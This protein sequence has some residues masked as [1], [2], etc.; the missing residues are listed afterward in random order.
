MG[1]RLVLFFSLLALIFCGVSIQSKKNKSVQKHQDLSISDIEKTAN[2]SPVSDSLLT[3]MT[4][5]KNES[6]ELR[7]QGETQLAVDKLTEAIDLRWREPATNEEYEKLAWI[8]TNRAYLYHERQGDFLAAKEDYLSALRQFESCEPSSYLV[9]RYVYQPLGNIYTRLGENEIAISMLEKFKRACE[10]SGETEALMN[11]YNDIGRAHMNSWKLEEAI[12]WFSKGIELDET[13]NFSLGLLY[14]SKA[15][16]EQKKGDVDEGYVSAEK[17][18]QNLDRVI[19]STDTSDF[20][21]AAA[22]RYKIGVLST[23]GKVIASKGDESRAHPFY[24][25]AVELAIEQYPDKHRGLARAF[26]DLSDS[27]MAIGSELKALNGYQLGLDAMLDGINLTDFKKNPA[28]SDL[29]AD[30]VIG[31]ALVQKAKTAYK[32]YQKERNNHDWLHVSVNAYLTYF[33]WVEVQR[34]EQ[35]EF[36]SKLD[37]ASEIHQIGESALMVL[38]E[39][40]KETKE[41]KWIDIAFQLMDQTKAIVLAEERG[42]KDLAEK[43]PKMRVMLRKQ[44]A[45]KFQRSRFESDIKKVGIENADNTTELLRVK[46]RLS[47]LDKESQLLDQDIRALFPSYR[48]EASAKLEG[49]ALVQLKSKLKKKNASVLSYFVGDRQV[50]AITG[51]PGRFKFTQFSKE[52]LTDR[53]ISFMGALNTPGSSSPEDYSQ[54]AKSIF[55]L[56]IG[57]E[58]ENRAENWVVLPDGM[59]N[60]LP[61]E[62]MVSDTKGG[63]FKKL[64]YLVRDHVIHYAPS[65]FFFAHEG[66]GENAKESFLG[67]APVF[68]NSKEYEFLPKS[69]GELESGTSL[70]SGEELT[71][72][73]ATKKQFFSKAE[74]YDILHI[75]TH[76]GTNSGTNNDAWM[77]FSDSKSTD[78][79]LEAHELLKLDLPASL[80]VLNACET[81]SG[82]VFRGEGPMSLARGFL[83]AGSESTVTNLWSVN[84]ESNAVIM[85]SFYEN[86]SE[87]QSP[88]QSL[89]EAKL[90]YLASS[91]VDDAGAHPYYWSSAILIGTDAPVIA[92]STFSMMAWLLIGLGSVTLVFGIVLFRKRRKMKNVA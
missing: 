87:T 89:N 46:K 42:F 5:L 26:V 70:F 20:H 55:D 61:F 19:Q 52:N 6:R 3:W 73:K 72:E 30:V 62:A 21:H 66:L 27:W 86:L 22:K 34:S 69:K 39:L 40:Y 43:N 7:D 56:L 23:M 13:D 88:S 2:E 15:E 58:V 1:K 75:S 4:D 44:N 54:A 80:V 77:V 14:S 47:E 63:S 53:T 57:K 71:D 85:K 25:K 28:K 38:F 37:A 65:A 84:H 59:L 12:E 35:F 16:A 81:G 33:D 60:G 91:E 90:D 36:N 92:P 11:A 64:N 83:N 82:T 24:K 50:Y 8:Y 79:K 49:K 45:L 51:V 68:K 29:Y 17:S 32:L 9:A 74:R 78:Y 31:E 10:D 67:I 41:S 48:R 76:A 18:I